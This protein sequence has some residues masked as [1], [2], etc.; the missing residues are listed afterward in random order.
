MT[1]WPIPK[2]AGGGD[3]KHCA[4]ARAIHVSNSHTKFGLILEKLNFDPPPNP[5]T[6]YVAQYPL[7]H[8]TYESA[9]FEV[10]TANCLGGVAFTRKYIL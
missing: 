1:F 5:I 4:V 10:A 3:Q 9:K 6:Q 7:H 8:A 2:V